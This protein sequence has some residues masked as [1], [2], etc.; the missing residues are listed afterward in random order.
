MPEEKKEGSSM[1]Q[2]G[3]CIAKWHMVRRTGKRSKGESKRKER[4]ENI[5]NP[6]RSMARYRNRESRYA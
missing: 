1:A 2:R 5:Q 3:K 6:K 4:Q